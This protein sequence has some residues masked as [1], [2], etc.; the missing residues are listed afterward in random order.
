M[1]SVFW[2]L[3]KNCRGRKAGASAR[4]L[5]HEHWVWELNPEPYIPPEVDRIWDIWG[6]YD[7]IPKTIFYLLKG[8]YRP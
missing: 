1:F 8:D 6:S 2:C 7:S 4:G 3:T 5:P